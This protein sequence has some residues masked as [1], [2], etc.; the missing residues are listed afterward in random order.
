[1]HFKTP[2]IALIA[3]GLTACA[4]SMPMQ[5]ARDAATVTRADGIAIYTAA[6]ADSQ[7]AVKTILGP[8]VGNSCRFLPTDPDSSEAGAL[9]QLRL[10]ALAMGASG[11]VGVRYERAGMS[12]ANDCW[13]SVT[14]SGT[15]VVLGPS[16]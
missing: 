13:N 5:D 12:Y 3:S 16:R 1:M 15:A 2:T 11:V 6:N 8:A 14:A 4:S 10:K 9:R 7:P